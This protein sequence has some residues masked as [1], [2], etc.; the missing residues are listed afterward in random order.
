[1]ANLGYAFVNDG[2]GLLATVTGIDLTSVASTNLFTVPAGKTLFVDEVYLHI[3]AA[4]T[5]TVATTVSVGKTTAFNEWSAITLLTG[6]NTVGQFVE[7]SSLSN[8]MLHQT[9]A[10]GET[11]AIKVTT[12]ATAVTLTGTVYIFGLI[13]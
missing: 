2:R 3:T 13:V 4:N 6:L 11:V 5:V 8:I 1:M 7:L 12:G 9:F 10:A